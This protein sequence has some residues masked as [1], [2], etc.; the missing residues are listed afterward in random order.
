LIFGTITL[1]P[2]DSSAEQ[3]ALEALPDL[4]RNEGGP[5]FAEPWQASAFAVAVSLSQ[6]GHFSWK[7]WAAALAEEL[8]SSAA[9]GEPDDGT[10]Y[11]HC[12]LATLE[13]LVVAKGLSQ[14]AELRSCKEAWADA[15]RHTPHGK[16]VELK[17]APSRT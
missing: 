5:V 1:N 11:Y 12:W 10:H 9:R 3:R 16:P 8:R 4:P 2:P 14:S 15:Y 13:R 7:E 6:Q 17:S